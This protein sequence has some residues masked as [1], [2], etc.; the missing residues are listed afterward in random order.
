[1]PIFTSGSFF[2]QLATKTSATSNIHIHYLRNASAEEVVQTLTGITGDKKGRKLGSSR[3]YSPG[4]SRSSRSRGSS[5]SVISG[6]SDTLFAGKIKITADKPTNSLVIIS[7]PQ[8]YDSL[9]VIIKKLDIKRKQVYV[10]GRLQTRE[11][12]DRDGNK[13]RTTEIVANTMQMLGAA[14]NQARADLNEVPPPA[15]DTS[16]IG[17]EE[18]VPF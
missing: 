5:S 12:E 16:G 2:A 11:W 1:M 4:R 15:D 17:T 13:R 18:D 6:F 3:S 7:S 10:E 9:K 14:G 8:D